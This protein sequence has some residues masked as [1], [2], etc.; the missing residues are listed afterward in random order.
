M[1]HPILSIVLFPF[2]HAKAD[3]TPA[4]TEKAKVLHYL[5]ACFQVLTTPNGPVANV[6]DGNV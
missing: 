6:I 4:K 3:D 5:E 2:L 1:G